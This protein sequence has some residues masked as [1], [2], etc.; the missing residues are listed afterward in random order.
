MDGE[1][2]EYAGGQR[3]SVS[4]L[5]STRT[6]GE[7]TLVTDAAGLERLRQLRGR[8]VCYRDG[9]GVKLWGVFHRHPWTPS[10]DGRLRYVSLT[11]QSITVSEAV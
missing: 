4:R 1:V 11:F 9:L 8:E 6:E 10:D 7:H 2:R 3:S 5:D